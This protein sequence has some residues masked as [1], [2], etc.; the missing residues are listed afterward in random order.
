M[1]GGDPPDWITD[2]VRVERT[3]RYAEAHAG[4]QLDSPAEGAQLSRQLREWY[5]Q[6]EGLGKEGA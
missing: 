6:L 3:L 2:R 1:R 5:R 4:D